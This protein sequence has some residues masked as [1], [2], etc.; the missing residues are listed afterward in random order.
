MSQDQIKIDNLQEIFL[1]RSIASQI[2]TLQIV[3]SQVGVLINLIHENS[4][5]SIHCTQVFN[6]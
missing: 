4:S 2:E 3:R 6:R 1:D 5:T